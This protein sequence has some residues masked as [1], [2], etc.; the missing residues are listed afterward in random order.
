MKN[1][2]NQRTSFYERIISTLANIAV[3]AGIGFA[4]YQVLQTDQ[5]E[6]QRTAVE[7]IREIRSPAFLKSYAR[8]KTAYINDDLDKSVE[9]VDDINYLMSVYD[10][11]AS[12]CANN[13][14]DKCIIKDSIFPSIRDLL[15]ILKSIS[16]CPKEDKNRFEA[17]VTSLARKDCS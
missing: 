15:K 3:I 7:A 9:M 8:L 17:F 10:N 12:L 16:F 2:Q 6:K 5:I 4:T 11:I 13:L 1:T 14:A